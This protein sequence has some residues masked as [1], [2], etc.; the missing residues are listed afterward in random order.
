[1]HTLLT[2][3]GLSVPCQGADA[4]VTLLSSRHPVTDRPLLS[5]VWLCSSA[6][7]GLCWIRL[8][9][10]P[11]C[12]SVWTV[13]VL[14]ELWPICCGDTTHLAGAVRSL[15]Q[16]A[17]PLRGGFLCPWGS[18]A[19]MPGCP[20]E[21]ATA[22]PC[23]G[24]SVPSRWAGD[25]TALA[26]RCAHAPISR[27]GGGGP[28]RLRSSLCLDS[29]SLPSSSSSRGIRCSDALVWAPVLPPQLAL[30]RLMA[31]GLNHSG[32]EGHDKLLFRGN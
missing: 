15:G 6:A 12:P 3:L 24:L 21:G 25:L 7:R 2:L 32:K 23:S 13:L 26:L 28:R 5:V 30:P 22:T 10:R 29:A 1:M 31:S 17:A 14:L 27:G 18:E 19:R 11:G 16:A 20:P 9:C 8:H 4:I